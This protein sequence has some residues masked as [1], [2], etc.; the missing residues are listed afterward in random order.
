MV[1]DAHVHLFPERVFEALWRWFD[2]HAWNIKYRMRAEEVVEFLTT[3]GIERIV[4]LLYSHKPD[5][6]RVLNQFMAEIARAHPQ[7]VPFGTVL[8]GEPD[9]DAIVD[10]AF[11]RLGMRGLKL[12]CHVQAIAPDDPRLDPIYERAA[13]AGLPVII[14]SGRGPACTGYPVDPAKLCSVDA[15]RRM[16]RRHPRLKMIVPHLGA[17]EIAAHFALLDEFEN[18]WLDTTMLLADFIAP[19]PDAALL[20][21]HARRVLYGTDFP[22]IPYEWS[23]ELDWLR[24]VPMSDAARAAIMH[25]NARALFG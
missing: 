18:L 5:M 19:P 21:R 11:G 9:A 24:A 16:L 3:R 14:H 13:D 1:I 12:H 17:D 7:V 10:E 8:P 22:N 20:E 4:A 23:R 15:T 2:K 6:A 25:E